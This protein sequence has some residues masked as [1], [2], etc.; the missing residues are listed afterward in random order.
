MDSVFRTVTILGDGIPI[1]IVS[2]EDRWR[3]LLVNPTGAVLIAQSANAIGVAPDL[4]IDAISV[5]SG[6]TFVIAPNQ[7]IY[8]VAFVGAVGIRLSFHI[9]DMM[10]E[11]MP[12]PHV[13]ALRSPC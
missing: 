8:A 12:H 7:A 11:N 13:T 5:V 3:R 10:K 1:R 2:D 9:S 4:P 6:Q